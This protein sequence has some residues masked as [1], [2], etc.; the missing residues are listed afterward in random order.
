MLC[1]SLGDYRPHSVRRGGVTLDQ[2]EI[3]NMV[4]RGHSGALRTAGIYIH[5]GNAGQ[6]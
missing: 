4:G 2:Q 6:T 5:D 3:G 1:I